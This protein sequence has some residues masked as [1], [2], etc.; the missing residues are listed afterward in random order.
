[1]IG[2]ARA[3][4]VVLASA[5]L[6]VAASLLPAFFGMGRI[7]F[8][9]ALAGGAAFVWTSVQLARAPSRALAMRNFHM[10]LAQL[11]TLLLAAFADV[12]WHG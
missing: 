5:V 1:V 4:R 2:S 6:L 8:A 3:A 11:T 9:A 7:Y 12:A 10:S